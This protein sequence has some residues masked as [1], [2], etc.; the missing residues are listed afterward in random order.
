MNLYMSVPN[1]LGRACR[2]CDVV[3]GLKR[4]RLIRGSTPKVA[5][6]IY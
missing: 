4:S 3:S 1:D 2:A 6:G 5:V